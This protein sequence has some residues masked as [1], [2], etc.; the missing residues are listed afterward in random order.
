MEY[1]HDGKQVTQA[2]YVYLKRQEAHKLLVEAINTYSDVCTAIEQEQ[3]TA[4][5][6]SASQDYLYSQIKTAMGEIA[7]AYARFHNIAYL[8]N[9]DK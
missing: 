8:G 2:T 4:E 7:P 3:E 1:Y 5:V 9:P 6:I